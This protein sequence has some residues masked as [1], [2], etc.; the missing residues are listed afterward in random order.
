MN[1]LLTITIFQPG[2]S[3]QAASAAQ[4]DLL[5]AAP[6]LYVKET[7]AADLRVIGSL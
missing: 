5:A 4:L 7:Y 3:A 1:V 2:L 6:A